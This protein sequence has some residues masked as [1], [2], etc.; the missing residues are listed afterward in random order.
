MEMAEK[1]LGMKNVAFGSVDVKH[2]KDIAKYLQVTKA[3]SLVFKHKGGLLNLPNI[4]LAHDMI[5]GISSIVAP[6]T[7]VKMPCSDLQKHQRKYVMFFNGK[8]SDDLFVKV[9]QPL[10]KEFGNEVL[11]AHSDDAEKCFVDGKSDL[12][13]FAASQTLDLMVA[14]KIVKKFG[15][16]HTESKLVIEPNQLVLLR[17]VKHDEPE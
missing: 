5:R 12:E 3:P 4:S 1:K 13:Y 8:A 10:A 17:P 15:S 7:S 6:P 16:S 14:S 9:Q 2:H 11:F